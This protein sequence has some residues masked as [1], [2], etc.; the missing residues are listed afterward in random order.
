MGYKLKMLTGI[1]LLQFKFNYVLGSCA[2]CPD[3]VCEGQDLINKATAALHGN[4]TFPVPLEES[5]NMSSIV[6]GKCPNSEMKFMAKC[7]DTTIR[8]RSVDWKFPDACDP[9]RLPCTTNPPKAK[10]ADFLYGEVFQYG[11]ERRFRCSEEDVALYRKDTVGTYRCL[12]GFTSKEKVQS[13]C[14]NTDDGAKWTD[15]LHSCT[16]DHCAVTPCANGG[17]CTNDDDGQGRT[18]ECLKTHIGESC[19]TEKPV[20]T[21]TIILIVVV[22]VIILVVVAVLGFFIWT[23]YFAS[24][25]AGQNP[26]ADDRENAGQQ[27]IKNFTDCSLPEGM[28]PDS[29]CISIEMDS[30]GQDE[31]KA[32]SDSDSDSVGV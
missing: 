11:N 3:P 10:H 20:T 2:G 1:L 24:P 31:H 28:R 32:Q 26:K 6:T 19:E 18:C 8:F 15:P 16:V 30:I 4:V 12:K 17:T 5:Y 29:E 23:K 22:V 9:D 27:G 14:I 13:T 25:A 7:W 21:G